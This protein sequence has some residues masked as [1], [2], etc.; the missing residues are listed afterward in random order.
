[1][2]SKKERAKAAPPKNPAPNDPP[3]RPRKASTTGQ[4]AA[5]AGAFGV[6][7]GGGAAAALVSLVGGILFSHMGDQPQTSA[8]RA[9]ETLGALAELCSYMTV[10]AGDFIFEQGDG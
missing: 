6:V 9:K 3:A 8:A 4:R 10:G 7:A 5:A 2:V 1:M